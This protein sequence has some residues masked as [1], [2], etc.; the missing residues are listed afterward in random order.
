MTWRRFFENNV[1]GYLLCDLREMNKIKIEGAGNCG[2]PMLMSI[3]SGMELLGGLISEDAKWN[4]DSG[5]KYFEAFYSN[6]FCNL[7]PDY[8]KY[9]I[10]T[11]MYSLIRHKLAHTFLTALKFQIAKNSEKSPITKHGLFIRLDVG[12]IFG[13]FEGAVANLRKDLEASLDLAH[14]V[15]KHLEQMIQKYGPLPTRETGLRSAVDVT[16]SGTLSA[17]IKNTNY[18]SGAT[19]AFPAENFANMKIITTGT[20]G[21][22]KDRGV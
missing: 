16:V 2:Y 7:H 18:S 13:D 19:T 8:S 10:E 6:Y 1:E 15:E 12:L 5:K 14:R 4:S 9:N 17:M 21:K 20:R 3:L 22:Q 11:E